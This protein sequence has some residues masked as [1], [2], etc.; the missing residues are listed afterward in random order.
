MRKILLRR[1]QAQE[2]EVL[3]KF[4]KKNQNKFLVDRFHTRSKILG[5]RMFTVY[6][7][8]FVIS[9]NQGV[10]LEKESLMNETENNSENESIEKKPYGKFDDTF[11]NMNQSNPFT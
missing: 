7:F 2:I 11:E 6:N 3:M 5:C 1:V 4:G 10:D 9:L 8:M